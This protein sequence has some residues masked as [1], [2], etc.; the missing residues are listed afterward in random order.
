MEYELATPVVVED[1]IL[2]ERFRFEAPAG[3]VKP[4]NEREEWALER[5]ATD[6]PDVCRRVKVAAGKAARKG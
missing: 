4:K 3:R 1:A 5:L 6:Q 2:G